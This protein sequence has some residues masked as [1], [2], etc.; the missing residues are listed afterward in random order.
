MEKQPL[1]LLV[2]D[3]EDNR[4]I[5][6]SL[7]T[8][9]SYAV[10]EAVNGK[11]GLNLARRHRPDLV[12]M[13]LTMPI[14]DGWEAVRCIRETPDISEVPVVV[15]TAHDVREDTWREAGFTGMLG[16]PC[17]PRRLLDTVRDFLPRPRADS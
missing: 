6:T 13:D 14:M 9:Y 7:L 4:V 12:L 11:D 10:L 5:F 1:I 2:D 16:K 8:H 15:L 3:N 17:D